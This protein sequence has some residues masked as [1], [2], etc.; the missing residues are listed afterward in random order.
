MITVKVDNVEV[1][2][3]LGKMSQRA[4]NPALAMKAISVLMKNDVLDHFKKEKGPDGTWKDLK[5]ATW[6][7]KEKHGYTHILNN[8]G[9]R[10]LQGHNLPDSNRT[11]AKVINDLIYAKTH[12]FGDKGSN[13]PK[14]PFLWIGDE[15]MRAIINLLRGW[16]KDGSV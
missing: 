1:Q 9:A 15:A 7:W 5:P 10:G 4:S 6:A 11:Q 2:K 16:I 8:H 12:Q 14:R 3:M 13:I